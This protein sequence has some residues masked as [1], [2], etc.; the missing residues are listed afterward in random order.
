MLILD[1]DALIKLYRAGVL[2]TLAGSYACSIPSAVYQEAVVNAK[3]L[4]PDAEQI[5]LIIQ[6][7]FQVINPPEVPLDRHMGF[8]ER[9]V[10]ALWKPTDIII[11]DDG[12]FLR[13]L[14]TQSISYLTPAHI[15]LRMVDDEVLDTDTAR[16]AIH[17][18]KPLINPS[19]Y[20]SA[21]ERLE[22]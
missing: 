17:L 15:I 4:Y 6:A 21:V 13:F 3:G 11:S 14:A 2:D 9:Q 16:M 20:Q 8:G 22:R 1:A 18:L 10:L 19:Q 5:D 12:E 7:W